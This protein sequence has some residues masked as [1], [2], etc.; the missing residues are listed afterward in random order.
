MVHT[1]SFLMNRGFMFNHSE[2]LALTC[3]YEN[4]LSPFKISKDYEVLWEAFANVLGWN[5][6]HVFCVDN[7]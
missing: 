6:S 2:G 4:T 7:P 3:R 1:S 5:P